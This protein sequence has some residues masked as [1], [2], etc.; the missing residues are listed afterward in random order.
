M[1]N[2]F[3]PKL[4]WCHQSSFPSSFTKP[5]QS[6]PGHLTPLSLHQST[7]P[8][9][10]SG[11]N[12]WEAAGPC[13]WMLSAVCIYQLLPGKLWQLGGTFTLK[14]NTCSLWAVVICLSR[15]L[16]HCIKSWALWVSVDSSLPR[17]CVDVCRNM[18]TQVCWGA[19]SSLSSLS[20]NG[21]HLWAVIF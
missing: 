7:N 11:E 6:L 1:T 14:Q 2:F 3:I 21:D 5:K 13:D 4:P 17:I 15:H 18:S 19:L 9:H 10:D 8:K 16:E 20:M 12:C